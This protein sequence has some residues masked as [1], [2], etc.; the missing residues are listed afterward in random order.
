M[1]VYPLIHCWQPG[2]WE[3]ICSGIFE[4]SVDFPQLFVLGWVFFFFLSKR[5]LQKSSGISSKWSLSIHILFTF[6]APDGAW[7]ISE[8]IVINIIQFKHGW[9]RV[10]ELQEVMCKSLI[11]FSSF[12]AF[13]TIPVE[14]GEFL[15]NS[16]VKF[17]LHFTF[18]FRKITYAKTSSSITSF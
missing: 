15:E 3:G 12:V 16:F 6:S 10:L 5:L 17:S 8:W 14:I 18:W 1:L 9:C 2:T 4:G 13:T 11:I 7:A